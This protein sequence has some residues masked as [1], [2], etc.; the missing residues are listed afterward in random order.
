MDVPGDD[1]IPRD[2]PML[3]GRVE[4]VP[5][6]RNSSRKLC[7]NSSSCPYGVDVRG[8]SSEILIVSMSGGHTG[9]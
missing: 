1:P 4:I 2:D 6:K 3:E 8:C 5:R 7:S 9:R